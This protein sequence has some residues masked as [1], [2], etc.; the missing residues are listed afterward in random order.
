MNP[1]ET[2]EQ[3]AM[4]I[5]PKYFAQQMSTEEF[6]KQAEEYTKKMVEVK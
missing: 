6:D 3:Q 5:E 1:N 2:Q 4:D